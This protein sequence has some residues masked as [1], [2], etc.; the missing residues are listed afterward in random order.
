MI[1]DRQVFDESH[2]PARLLHREAVVNEALRTWEPNTAGERGQNIVIHG[3]SGVGKTVLARYCLRELDHEAV[4]QAVVIDSQDYQEGIEAVLK[5]LDPEFERDR[6][7]PTLRRSTPAHR[8][9]RLRS[10]WETARLKLKCVWRA[11]RY[12]HPVFWCG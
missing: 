7:L 6:Q 12:A 5:Q 10:D 1:T 11:C 9:R 3:P 4:A 8:L 2:L